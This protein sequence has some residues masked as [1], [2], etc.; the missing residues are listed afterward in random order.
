MCW[1]YFSNSVA[2]LLSLGLLIPWA[3]IRMAR[4]RAESLKLEA[5]GSL[6]DFL[7]GEARAV[8]ATGEEMSDM[9]DFDFAI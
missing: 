4:Y 9:L 2:I 8:R 7:A 6:D 5:R 3:R 1:L